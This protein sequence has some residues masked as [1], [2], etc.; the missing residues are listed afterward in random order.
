MGHIRMVWSTSSQPMAAWHVSTAE[1][2][3]RPRSWSMSLWISRP[4][5]PPHGCVHN[6]LLLWPAAAAVTTASAF[7]TAVTST[8]LVPTLR[9]IRVVL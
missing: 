7:V 6:D 8:Q 2:P 4:G 1:A 9:E 3:V 5:A